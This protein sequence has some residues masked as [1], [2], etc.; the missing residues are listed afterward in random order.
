MAD[1]PLRP[2]N[3]R[4][5]GG[6]LPRQQANRT[7]APLQATCAFDPRVSCGI[8]DS[9]PSLSPTRR[10]I[11]TRYSPVR[12]C[13]VTPAV[14]LACVKHAASVRSEPGSN[15][16]VHLAPRAPLTRNATNA[17]NK[18]LTSVHRFA[19]MAEATINAPHKRNCN[20]SNGYATFTPDRNTR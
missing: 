18:T 19:P 2:A 17:T 7:R 1:H 13:W 16:Q 15:S 5:L 12:H 4:R 14:R 9:F 11:P 6:L 8:S 3:D 20:A 10:Q